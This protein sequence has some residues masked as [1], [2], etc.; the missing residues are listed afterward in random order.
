MFNLILGS[1][2]LIVLAGLAAFLARRWPSLATAL[3]AGGAVVGGAAG[4]VAS[5]VALAQGK[6]ASISAAW[7]TGLGASFSIGVDSLSL[8]FLV[9]VFGL[10]SLAAAFGAGYLR[11]STVGRRA[12]AAWLAYDLLAASMAVALLARNAVLFLVAWEA[13]TL[14]SWFLV[15]FDHER[16]EARRAGMLYL[17]ASQLGTASLLV[18]FTL[19]G[20]PG[21]GAEAGLSSGAFLDFSRLAANTPAAASTVFVLAMIGFGTKA[22][23]VPLHVWLPEA[24]PAAPSHV[25]ALMSGVM[26][27][28]G[29]YGLVRT[30]GFLGAPRAWWGWSILAVGVLSGTLGVLFALAQH[31]LKRLLAYHSV[32]NIGI[33]AIGIGLG[34]LGTAYG[35]PAV[36]VLG[37]AGAL[38]HVLN[39]AVFKG[40]LF[41]GAGAV[42]HSAGTREL[43]RLGG[44]AKRMPLTAAAFLVAAAAISGL[45]PLNG[46]LSEFLVFSGALASARAQPIAS[47]LLAATVIVSLG[48]IG[49]LAAACFSKAFGIVFLGEPRE[50][51][52]Q[53]HEPRLLMLVPMGIMAALCLGIGIAGPRLLPAL[54]PL[55]RQASGVPAAEAAAGL[56]AAARPLAGITIAAAV[57]AGL[58]AS[59]ALLRFLLLRGRR[60]E[61]GVTWDCGYASPSPRMQYTASSFAQPVTDMFRIVLRP[62]RRLPEVRGPF[63]AGTRF[64]SETHDLFASRFYR[65]VM[66]IAGRIASPL[67]RLQHGRLHLYVLYILLA[68]LALAAWKL[69]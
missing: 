7:N 42:Q 58:A 24:H 53:S 46:F 66:A 4:L 61:R 12:G 17:V 14:S 48:L 6:T 39:H 28:L 29:I 38:L 13:M 5:A 34:V 69:G 8:F 64:D 18:M 44:L 1:V 20:G 45:P 59:L 19:L 55:V 30:L 33:I 65:P 31:D 54:L 47:A 57:F 21:A 15:A 43:D 26:I 52:P 25:S 49:G 50:A 11:P 36:A 63:P 67:R 68:L 37:W 10:T 16:E 35:L 22:G 40:L 2:A 23:F 62:H 56:A 60:V 32:E 9:P 3:G 27:K 41:L 51:R